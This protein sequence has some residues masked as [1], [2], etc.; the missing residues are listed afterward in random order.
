MEGSYCI[1]HEISV[2][3][4]G[5]AGTILADIALKTLPALSLGSYVGLGVVYGAIHA[6]ALWYHN[7]RWMIEPEGSLSWRCI[8]RRMN[9]DE[10]MRESGYASYIVSGLLTGSCFIS[11]V[12][13]WPI[14]NYMGTSG[15]H[16]FLK[17]DN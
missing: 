3:L 4:L 6:R 1:M 12:A 14:A 16:I 10:Y 15:R 9:G 8:Y 11:T 2:F 7:K 13:F 17:S 5:T